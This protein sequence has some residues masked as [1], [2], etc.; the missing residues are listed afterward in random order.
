MGPPVFNTGGAA[1]GVARWVRLPCAPAIRR[2][3]DQAPM[4][5]PQTPDDHQD[6][7]DWP[8]YY[9]ATIGREPRP[10][11]V[12]GLGLAAEAGMAPGQAVEIGFGD[13]TETLGAARGR[14]A[15]PGD[16]PDARRR[17]G[18]PAARAA[19]GRVTPR[20]RDRPRRRRSSCRRST[21]ST[22]AT[23]SRSSAP[24]RSRASGPTS[25]P[26][27]GPA[28]SWSSTCSAS[29]TRGPSDPDMT[30]VDAERVQALA[31]RPRPG[32]CPRARERRRLVRRAEALARVR[33]RR[34]PAGGRRPDDA[35]GVPPA[36]AQ[37]RA[38]ARGRAPRHRRPRP[39]GGARDGARRRGRGARAPGGPCAVRRRRA[40][41]RRSARRSPPASRPSSGSPDPSA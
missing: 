6:G 28:G 22:P 14:L 15:R 20:D 31:R 35:G 36:P 33:H 7:P 40:R 19:V 8:A 25:S 4:I 39:G 17:G 10:L 13:G 16:R 24:R 30:F 11:F 37:R 18:P 29:A 1:L 5:E 26:G 41:R 12:R 3:I 34:A 9:R 2:G 21:C 23:P 38:R 27:S 32:R